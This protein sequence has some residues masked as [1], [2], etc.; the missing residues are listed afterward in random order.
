VPELRLGGS[1]AALKANPWFD[2]F[3][4]DDLY[5]RKLRTPYTPPASKII[6]EK[7]IQAAAKLAKP[8]IN[9]IKLEQE[10]NK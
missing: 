10:K 1:F 6:S 2:N 3:N 4:W 9:E 5:N 8:V 7:D